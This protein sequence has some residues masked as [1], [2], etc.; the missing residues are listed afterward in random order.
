[1]FLVLYNEAKPLYEEYMRLR[2]ENNINTPMDF[3]CFLRR[4]QRNAEKIKATY[5][6]ESVSFQVHVKD[7]NVLL[8]PK[9]NKK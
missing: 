6:C 7:G 4:L 2:K 8:K 5:H 3:D 9:I 1:Q